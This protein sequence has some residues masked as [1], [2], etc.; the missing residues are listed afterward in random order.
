[1]ENQIQTTLD[2][3]AE[4][5]TYKNQQ[6]GN[7]A[8]EPLKIFGG[9]SNVGTRIDDKL[10]RIKNAESLRKNDVADLMGY[11][12]LVCIEQGW[13]NFDEFKD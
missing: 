7:S 6:Y 5:L 10:A 13:D 2:S 8:L 4:L 3:L 1:M 9:K 12:V 11:L